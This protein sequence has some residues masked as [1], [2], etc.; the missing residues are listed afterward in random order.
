M[1]WQAYF[2]HNKRHVLSQQTRVCHDKSMLVA[3][4][5]LSQQN[6]VWCDKYLSRQ[7]HVCRDKH[8]FVATSIFLSQPKMILMA[9]PTRVHARLYSE[10]KPESE[11]CPC[12]HMAGPALGWGQTAAFASTVGTKL[13]WQYPLLAQLVW[14]P[15][16]A[17]ER[18]CMCVC[19]WTEGTWNVHYVGIS[20]YQFIP[21]YASV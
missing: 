10:N 17:W 3:T 6:Y 19:V 2:C 15:Q 4:K 21:Y 14:S 20:T 7:T 16:M 5:V 12:R 1:S 8:N 9:A 13:E 11:V 18:T